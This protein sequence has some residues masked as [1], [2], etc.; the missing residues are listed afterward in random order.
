MNQ[1]IAAPE[2]KSKMVA[3]LLAL[4]LGV[5]GADRFYLGYTGLGVAKL[6]TMGGCG[7]WLLIDLI[8]IITGS[9]TDSDGNALV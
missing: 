2:G 3:I 4:F 6:L 5:F 1:A 9:I 8:M 7:L